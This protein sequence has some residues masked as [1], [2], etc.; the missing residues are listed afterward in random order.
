MFKKK[1]KIIKKKGGICDKN[2]FP[3]KIQF[4]SPAYGYLNANII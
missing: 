2:I 3:S 1:E 4:L